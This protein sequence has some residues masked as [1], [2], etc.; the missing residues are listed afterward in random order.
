MA[1]EIAPSPPRA[2]C[3][4]DSKGGWLVFERDGGEGVAFATC[5]GEA[6]GS[7]FG[8]W[9]HLLSQTRGVADENRS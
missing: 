1:L 5:R 6:V 2:G 9:I 4:D 8:R 7:A 3:D